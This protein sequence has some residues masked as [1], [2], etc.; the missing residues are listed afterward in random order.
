VKSVDLHDDPAICTA[1]IRPFL[2]RGLHQFTQCRSGGRGYIEGGR[3]GLD[4]RPHGAEQ[5]IVGGAFAG[6]GAVAC[7]MFVL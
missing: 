3:C 1:K 2:F 5:M 6:G 4:P 7:D